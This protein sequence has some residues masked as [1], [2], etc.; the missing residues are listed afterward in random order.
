MP[1]DGIENDANGFDKPGLE[2]GVGVVIFAEGKEYALGVGVM[3]M[4]SQE[5]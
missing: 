3:T 1:Q 2:K 5:V 4:S